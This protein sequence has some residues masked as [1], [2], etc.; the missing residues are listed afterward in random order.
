MKTVTKLFIGAV[1]A[2]SVL[3]CGQA[4]TRKNSQLEEER[5]QSIFDGKTLKG[6]KPSAPGF[7]T[8][9]DGAI[10]GKASRE[11]TQSPV[12]LVWEGGKVQDF[13]LRFR[14]RLDDFM[15]HAEIHF[16]AQVNGKQLADGYQADFSGFLQGIKGR[17]RGEIYP[18]GELAETGES[19]RLKVD[20]QKITTYFA[21]RSDLH[22]GNWI[23]DWVDYEIKAIGN[24]IILE[25]GGKKYSELIDER[26][27]NRPKPGV[28]AIE[29]HAFG[30]M[31]FQIKEIELRV[32]RQQAE[33][34][35]TTLVNN[36]IATIDAIFNELHFG[37]AEEAL[38]LLK[39]NPLLVNVQNASKQTPLHVAA[40][41]GH[42]DVVAWLIA[43]GADVNSVAYSVI[44]LHLAKT[45]DVAR[46]L[47]KAGGN[48]DALDGEE[49]TPLRYAANNKN[50]E[51][52]KV[53]LESGYKMDLI[54][55][56]YL[57][58]YE[59]IAKLIRENPQSV[60]ISRRPVQ[61]GERTETGNWSP[62]MVAVWQKDK[63]LVQMLLDAGAD[64]NDKTSL[65]F[66][67]G[68]PRCMAITP[69][70]NAL[71]FRDAEMVKLLLL[72]GAN[73]DID[74]LTQETLMQHVRAN[75]DYYSKEIIALLEKEWPKK[76]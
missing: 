38:E 65:R 4:Q 20:G 15:D 75:A 29:L 46:I 58:D 26:A 59:L 41:G 48:L 67:S 23:H 57:G 3:T 22:I 44:P 35:E 49:L 32:L 76:N 1:L 70:T 62:L 27:E 40:S 14:C 66:S 64:V 39:Q 31:R 51:V 13:R 60:N 72:H 7:F 74:C 63:K 28:I 25:I 55:A 17:E 6:W 24:H 37:S 34:S 73:T 9:E 68:P 43:N 71:T 42:K 50:L 45:A 21:E 53:I 2:I 11:Q 8:V 5:W 16:R 33:D 54:S 10:T 47:I 30:E 61:E 36:R 12:F 19:N 18:F 56:I 52:I 69:L